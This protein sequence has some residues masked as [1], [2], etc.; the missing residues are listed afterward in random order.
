MGRVVRRGAGF[1]GRAL[2]GHATVIDR[3]DIGPLTVDRPHGNRTN[4]W[5]DRP[6]GIRPSAVNRPHG[7]GHRAGRGD[8][9]VVRCCAAH[10]PCRVCPRPGWATH[11]P[12][13]GGSPAWNPTIGGWR[14][15]VVARVVRGT[16]HVAVRCAAELFV[17]LPHR[18]GDACVAPTGRW[19]GLASLPLPA[20]RLRS[21]VADRPRPKRA[22]P[23]PVSP[24]ARPTPS[25]PNPPS[26]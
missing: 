18:Q 21:S 3:A 24:R 14:S 5:V 22:P 20:T 6:R 4:A 2:G 11:R 7:P 1:V 17:A 9:C 10:A 15:P 16:R 8:A 23:P 13:L 25:R 26:R 12:L 19:A